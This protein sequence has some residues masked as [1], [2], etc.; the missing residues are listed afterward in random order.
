MQRRLGLDYQLLDWPEYQEAYRQPWRAYHNS[1]HLAL[2][3][4][5]AWELRQELEQPKLFFLA[6]LGHD[7]VYQ[8]ERK[9]NEFESAKTFLASTNGLVSTEQAAYIETL[10]LATAKHQL[11]DPAPADAAYFLDLDMLILAAPRELYK[12]YCQKIA[13]EYLPIYGS[14]LYTAGRK[15]V[16]AQFLERE[17]IYFRDEIREDLEAAARANLAWELAQL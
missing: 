3:F 15:Q 6:I 12:A 13:A 17:Q 16:L 2:F 11:P 8:P 10:I 7:L 9:D 4:A 5:N 1:E 14:E